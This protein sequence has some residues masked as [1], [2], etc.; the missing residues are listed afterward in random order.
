MNF[1]LTFLLVYLVMSLFFKG[2]TPASTNVSAITI[3]PAKTDFSQNQL[4]TVKIKNNTTSDATVK[5]DCPGEPLDVFKKNGDAW[6][7]LSATSKEIDCSSYTPEF[8]LKA[9]SF[10]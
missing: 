6:Q 3:T 10:W 7:Q 5:N 2:S 4:V 1:V 9:R 8:Q